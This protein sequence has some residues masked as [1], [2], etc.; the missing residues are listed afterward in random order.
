MGEVNQATRWMFRL[1]NEVVGPVDAQQ[2]MEKLRVGEITVNTEVR[3][4]LDKEFTRLVNVPEL[5]VQRE[6][7]MTGTG[8]PG[9][10]SDGPKGAPQ[11]KKPREA[12]PSTLTRGSLVGRYV[13]VEPIGAGGMGQVY[14]AVDPELGR[15]V[16]IKLVLGE[17]D[18]S[19]MKSA[20]QA[21]LVREAQA[22]AQLSHPNVVSVFDVGLLGNQVF[23]AME[24]V[25]G[26]T[27]TRWVDETPRHWRE[28]LALFQEAGRGL[29]AAHQAGL[30]HR[31]FKPDNVLIGRDGR[32]RVTDFG[33]AR[34]TSTAPESHEAIPIVI[35]T[36]ESDSGRNS[37]SS[38]LTNPDG[39]IGTPGYIAPEQY[40]GRTSDARSDQFAFAVTLFR[41]LFKQR[42]FPGESPIELFQSVT[43]GKVSI[44]PVGPSTAPR[45]V[46]KVL[47]KA[48]NVD[49]TQRYAG[50]EE[51]L[52]ALGKDPRI[53][54]QRALTVVATVG[55]IVVAG[56]T[57][58]RALNQ[59]SLVCQGL[60]RP[61]RSLWNDTVEKNLQ[62]AFLGTGETYAADTWAR[63]RTSFDTF[64][65][66][67][68]SM[69]ADSCEATRVR[70]EQSEEVMTLRTGCLDSKLREF[71]TLL[72]L[73]ATP[74]TR[75]LATAAEASQKLGDIHACGDVQQLL[76]PVKPPADAATRERVQGVRDE[77]A[78]TNALYNAGKSQ[79]AMQRLQ[80][81]L[82][83]STQLA[84]GPVKA[85]V[86]LRLAVM[87][88]RL[89]DFRT[90]SQ[91]AKEA[92]W[93]ALEVKHDRVFA[94]AAIELVYL[95]GCALALPEAGLEFAK[96]AD[97]TLRRMGD[98]NPELVA[99]LL[100]QT[101]AV[102]NRQGRGQEAI[103]KLT[104]ALSL[105]E[106]TPGADPLLVAVAYHGLGMAHG[107]LEDGHQLEMHRRAIEVVSTHLGA[108]HPYIAVQLANLG[109]VFREK[110]QYAQALA[111]LEESLR[112]QERSVSEPNDVRLAKTILE[113]GE[114]HQSQGHDREAL[115]FLEKALAIF[116]A[117]LPPDHS[118]FLA[119]LMPLAQAQLRLGNGKVAVAILERA[120]KIAHK[121]PEHY[122][123]DRA[124]T[125]FALAQALWSVGG[126][127]HRAL[128]LVLQAKEFYAKDPQDPG[129]MV[130]V[131]DWLRKHGKSR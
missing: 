29:L 117:R 14:S 88:D 122:Y 118:E 45:W 62:G 79:L 31:D 76:A 56:V 6:R 48:L 55:L 22:M 12:K 112:I 43:E 33:L 66:A 16:A 106:K 73:Y 46:L 105:L 110:G 83:E 68:V 28:T 19:K 78:E 39:V 38:P 87:H 23:L 24:Y 96:L 125:S 13:I 5:C 101:A 54:V 58:A 103:P 30:M 109:I 102:F 9:S 47:L 75:M 7:T 8:R 34:T 100:I 36:T 115:P 71:K 21:R 82:Q 91:I 131:E 86:L 124:M 127:K 32:V 107:M 11:G 92:L 10:D 98:G 89:G 121:R 93:L 57:Y 90:G 42:P 60:E 113:V 61:I 116:E 130:K 67:W 69:R 119:P 20:G 74:D 26:R 126:D 108:E 95:V 27:L 4:E 80:T 77:L 94:E 50:M 1:A 41:A 52:Q 53:A 35:S 18:G 44:P 81:A 3:R 63:V 15:K 25:D 65:R 37:L 72:E 2:L 85:E 128:E 51:M 97:A 49:P 123:Q 64:D 120:L 40:L 99:T 129:D 70:G 114:L 84:Y 104:E 59:Q 111:A 17:A